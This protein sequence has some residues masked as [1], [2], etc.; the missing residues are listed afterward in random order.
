MPNKNNILRPRDYGLKSGNHI[1]L[2]Y[3]DC[4]AKKKLPRGRGTIRRWSSNE[5]VGRDN[6]S[7]RRRDEIPSVE[8]CN[9]KLTLKISGR[10]F[11]ARRILKID[12]DE[13]CVANT[14]KLRRLCWKSKR[15]S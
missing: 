5:V 12:R 15:L 2:R 9:P 6:A 11:D 13:Y 7:G 4:F 3:H 8:D 10:F 1:L 14:A